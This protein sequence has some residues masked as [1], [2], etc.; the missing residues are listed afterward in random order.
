MCHLVGWK[1]RTATITRSCGVYAGIRQ[2]EGYVSARQA[3]TD[4]Q[5]EER[6]T[7]PSGQVESTD[8]SPAGTSFTDFVCCEALSALEISEHLNLYQL[9]S[10]T[11]Q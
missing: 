4:H 1:T 10:Q 9:K 3:A 2:A 5:G 8:S 7:V 11:S 6:E